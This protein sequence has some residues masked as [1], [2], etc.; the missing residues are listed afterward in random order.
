MEGTGSDGINGER[1]LEFIL[2]HERPRVRDLPWDN[3][4]FKFFD[5]NLA[6]FRMRLK[7]EF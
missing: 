1:E 3:D 4:L 6:E 2:F 7:A 5:D